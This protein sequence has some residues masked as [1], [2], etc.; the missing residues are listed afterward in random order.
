VHHTLINGSAFVHPK[1]L[2]LE[3]THSCIGLLLQWLYRTSDISKF[4]WWY[5]QLRNRTATRMVQGC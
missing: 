3:L 4:N 2:G 5:R 1:A